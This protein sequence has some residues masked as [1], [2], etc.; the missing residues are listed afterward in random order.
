L[1][2]ESCTLSVF[3]LG[4]LNKSEERSF[5]C[6]CRFLSSFSFKAKPLYMGFG[7]F[8]LAYSSFAF[9]SKWARPTGAPACVLEVLLTS[10]ALSLALSLSFFFI[11]PPSRGVFNVLAF[12][13]FICLILF[14]FPTQI[15]CV[16]LLSSSSTRLF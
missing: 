14:F 13:L 16:L 3:T 4:A 15:C 11:F 5:F 2:R 12:K 10:L 9:F 7:R 8:H 1:P 6:F